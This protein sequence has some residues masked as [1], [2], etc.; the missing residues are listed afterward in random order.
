MRKK[1]LIKLLE[2]ID[3]NTKV[4]VIKEDE[5]DKMSD[6][7]YLSICGIDGNNENGYIHLVIKED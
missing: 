3:D 2:N 4:Y 1:D 7:T 6:F 5:V